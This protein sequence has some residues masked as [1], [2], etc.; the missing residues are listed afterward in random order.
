MQKVLNDIFRSHPTRFLL[1]MIAALLLVYGLIHLPLRF[2]ADKVPP[3]TEINDEVEYINHLIIVVPDHSSKV[4][5]VISSAL[6]IEPLEQALLAETEPTE[7]GNEL[8]LPDRPIEVNLPDVVFASAESGNRHIGKAGSVTVFEPSFPGGKEALSAYLQQEIE[9]PEAYR[10]LN[11]QGEVWVKFTVD[12]VGRIR[13]P[14]LLVESYPRFNKEALRVIE[15]MPDWE[16]ARQ[17]TTAVSATYAI[18]IRF[19]IP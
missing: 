11:M 8:S 16:P 5:E 10:Q 4:R 13:E 3:F 17:D 6:R 19:R 12:S 15:A 14:E 18:P 7:T 2:K 9:F 1:S